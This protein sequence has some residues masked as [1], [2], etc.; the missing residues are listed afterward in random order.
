MRRGSV[1]VARK[2]ELEKGRYHI[3][4]NREDYE[5]LEQEYG[6]NSAKPI[7]VSAAVSAIV[8]AKVLD[9]KAKAAEAYEQIARSAGT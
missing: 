5:F 3:M 8:H 1:T 4:L 2:S 7:G 6:K 9:L